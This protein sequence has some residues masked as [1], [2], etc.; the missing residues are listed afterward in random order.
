[1]LVVE[2]A[3]VVWGLDALEEHVPAN[4]SRGRERSPRGAAR[5]EPGN[6]LRMPS[7]PVEPARNAGRNAMAS[8]RRSLAERIADLLRRDPERLDRAV[9]VG[10]IRREWLER[11]GDEAI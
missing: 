10:L 1:L 6:V 8:L 5:V 2:A 7:R 9:E 11:P 4:Y 3:D